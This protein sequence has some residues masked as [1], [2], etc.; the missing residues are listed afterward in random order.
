MRVISR[1]LATAVMVWWRP[2]A[3]VC[4]RYAARV[5][6]AATSCWRGAAKCAS[7]GKGRTAA[8]EL[9][10]QFVTAAGQVQWADASS[11]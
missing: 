7:S 10:E 9:A 3:T 2:G 5:A 1:S 6:A 11:A 4:R 8:P